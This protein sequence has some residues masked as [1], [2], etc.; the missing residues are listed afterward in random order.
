MSFFKSA[1]SSPEATTYDV[2]TTSD[3]VGIHNATAPSTGSDY[4]FNSQ[5]FF[6]ES[7]ANTD[8]DNFDVNSDEGS[9]IR[10]GIDFVVSV[11]DEESGN[12][13]EENDPESEI[14]ERIHNLMENET[15]DFRAITRKLLEL[16]FCYEDM[17]SINNQ[18]VSYSVAI[19]SGNTT[20]IESATNSLIEFVLKINN[21]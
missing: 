1:L 6:H 15:K 7:L 4:E 21:K 12:L 10:E 5:P 13:S 8:K 18:V 3:I 20:E 19:N 16:S 9:L 2:A 17:F 11:S 14:L